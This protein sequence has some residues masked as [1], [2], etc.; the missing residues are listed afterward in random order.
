[1]KPTFDG[2]ADPTKNAP[3][4]LVNVRSSRMA[5]VVLLV[6]SLKVGTVHAQVPAV[7][8]DAKPEPVVALA[9]PLKGQGIGEAMMPVRP[10]ARSEKLPRT[11]WQH[12]PGNAI[13]TRAA[14]AALKDYGSPLVEMVPR[15]IEN[16]CPAYATNT[17]SDRR[18]FWVGYLSALAKFESTYKPWAVGG[19]GKW[20][21]LLQILPATARGYKCN[22]GTG[23]ALKNG[24]ANLSCGVRIMAYT[25]KRDGVIHGR[26]S[27][28]RGVSA[29]WGPMRSEAKRRDMSNWLRKQ[30]YCK[31]RSS[32]RPRARP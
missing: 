1:M 22:V 24:A 29:D 27:K 14:L 8:A 15:D 16:W 13:W 28:W 12:M 21:G 18:A 2:S 3:F 32:T 25:V 23:E 10:V 4:K 11:R 5:G 19:G 17:D 31:L 20:Y 7:I 6:L 9:A 26:D 30:N